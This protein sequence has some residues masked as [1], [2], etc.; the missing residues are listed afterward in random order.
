MLTKKKLNNIH[1]LEDLQEIGRV[2]VDIGHRGGKVGLSSDIVSE[3]LNIP[4][5]L[6]PRMIGAYVNYLGGGLRGSIQTSSYSSEIVGK[7]KELLDLLLEACVRVYENLED[8]SGLNDEEYEDGETNWD[9]LATKMSRQAGISS[10][11]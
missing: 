2:L 10:A 5:H 1:T 8:E 3:E 7:K 9:A 4:S 6:L 11:Y